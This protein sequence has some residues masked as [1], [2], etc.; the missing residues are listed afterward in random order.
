[1]CCAHGPSSWPTRTTNAA[2]YQAPAIGR[3]C[4]IRRAGSRGHYGPHPV[5]RGPL[6][7]RGPTPSVVVRAWARG[8]SVVVSVCVSWGR[9]LGPFCAQPF[10]PPGASP[11]RGV[12]ARKAVRGSVWRGAPA[13]GYAGPGPAHSA[14]CRGRASLAAPP[15]APVFAPGPCPRGGLVGRLRAFSG[16]VACSRPPSV[17]V[18]WWSG[19]GGRGGRLRA[20]FAASGPGAPGPAPQRGGAALLAPRGAGPF[21]PAC[22][23]PLRRGS[24]GG[25]CSWAALLGLAG[26]CSGSASLPPERP[27]FAA[28]RRAAA[29]AIVGF[30]PRHTPVCRPLRGALRA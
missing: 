22:F 9:P 30:L 4:G 14:R 6:L 7:R 3:H 26:P 1:L 20:R 21:C 13:P 28:P 11:R 27:C 23:R 24:S 8:R 19:C 10:P 18:R 2:H 5:P 17:S 12:K 25:G 16:P 29:T 15:Q